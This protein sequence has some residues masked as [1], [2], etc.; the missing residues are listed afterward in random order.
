MPTNKCRKNDG[1][2]ISPFANHYSN[3]WFSK[4]PTMDMKTGSENVMRNRTFT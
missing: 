1:I 2:R 4:G 3:N